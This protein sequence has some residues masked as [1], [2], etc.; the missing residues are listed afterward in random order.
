MLLG[1]AFAKSLFW[2]GFSFL[3]FLSFFAKKLKKLKKLK[4]DC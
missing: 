3:S 2:L 1:Q 4:I